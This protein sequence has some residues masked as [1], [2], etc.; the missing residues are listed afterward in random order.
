MNNI[1]IFLI[2]LL[3][4]IS[5]IYLNKNKITYFIFDNNNKS[6]YKFKNKD[7]I[8][9]NNKSY[10]YYYKFKNKDVIKYNNK[11][12]CYDLANNIHKLK[13]KCSAN[14]EC[15]GFNNK[16][17]FIYKIPDLVPNN[18]IDTYLKI[19]KYKFPFPE[20]CHKR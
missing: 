1:K 6:Y 8:K 20:C 13:K 17:H 10:D 16:G 15:I 11:N 14:P 12:Y 7:V 5:I 3:L 18:N 19:N 2:I 4:I 9:Y